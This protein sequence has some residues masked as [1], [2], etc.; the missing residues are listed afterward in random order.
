MATNPAFDYPP[1]AQPLACWNCHQPLR[2][3]AVF[4]PHCRWRV[5]EVPSVPGRIARQPVIEEGQPVSPSWVAP[6]KPT[7]VRP[8][9]K[10]RPLSGRFVAPTLPVRKPSDATSNLMGK[11]RREQEEGH[12][13][14]VQSGP[15]DK[16]IQM[17]AMPKPAPEPEAKPLPAWLQP[18]ATGKQPAITP[19]F[20][21]PSGRSVPLFEP[22]KPEPYPPFPDGMIACIHCGG[23]GS[24]YRKW[25]AGTPIEWDKIKCDV[26]L[27]KGRVLPPGAI[28]QPLPAADVTGPTAHVLEAVKVEPEPV[29]TVELPETAEARQ[30]DAERLARIMARRQQLASMRRHVFYSLPALQQQLARAEAWRDT[31]EELV[32]DASEAGEGSEALASINRVGKGITTLLHH[33]HESILYSDHMHG[34]LGEAVQADDQLLR[35]LV[36]QEVQKDG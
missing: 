7:P 24:D 36:Q 18:A 6:A 23:R 21:Q 33:L 14:F 29:I 16:T 30:R 26:C 27:G 19:D 3:G 34:W 25:K 31:L 20:L 32:N 17:R 1:P 13:L 4:C 9:T 2:S 22:P 5:D 15:L 35:P 12:G 8:D 11:L 28:P 10:S